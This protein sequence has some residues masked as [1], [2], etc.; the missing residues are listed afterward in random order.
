MVTAI[1]LVNMH[2]LKVVKTF[3]FLMMRSLNVS[4][5][6]IFFHPHCDL[7]CVELYCSHHGLYLF[8]SE[9]TWASLAPRG[10]RYSLPVG[11]F[12]T[13][14]CIIWLPM[15]IILFI[16]Q[17]WP[18]FQFSGFPLWRALY[19]LPLGLGSH[20]CGCVTALLYLQPCGQTHGLCSPYGRA[21][22]L[23]P[24]WRIP[25]LSWDLANSHQIPFVLF[26]RG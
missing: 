20:D 16:C 13:Q 11:S 21:S 24:C 1:S 19:H 25:R 3:F 12:F 4:S 26:A 2:H 8:S 18:C 9:V 5:S 17:Q 6:N 15:I 14:R 23:P 22:P 7:A 10:R